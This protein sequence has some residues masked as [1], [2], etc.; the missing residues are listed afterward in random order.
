MFGVLEIILRRDPVPGQG[1]GA[2]QLQVALIVSLSVLRLPRLGAGEPGRSG[3]WG[4]G[5][6]RHGVGISVRLCRRGMTSRR[7]FHVGPCAATA[8][9]VRH[10]LEE[11]SACQTFSARNE[12]GDQAS[13]EVVRGDWAALDTSESCRTNPSRPNLYRNAKRRFQP[14]GFGA[15]RFACQTAPGS[16]CNTLK[17]LD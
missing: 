6:S 12:G 5:R 17:A 14:G 10:S 8:E 15:G 2:R 1:F 7:V 16:G 9:A 13:W 4:L 11:L 3:F